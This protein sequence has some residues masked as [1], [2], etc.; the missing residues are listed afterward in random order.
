MARFLRRAIIPAVVVVVLF[1]VVF[2]IVRSAPEKSAPVA[3]DVGK[4]PVRVYG[5]IEPLGGPVFVGAQAARAVA[6]IAAA[7][8]DTV[9]AGQ[10]LVVCEN[11]VEVAQVAA[12]EGRLGAARRAWA[13]SRDSYQRAAG[14]YSAKGVSEQDFV[15]VR[16][17]AE[18]DSATMT[19]A[20]ADLELARAQLDRLTL[21]APVPGVVYK[22]DVRLGSTLAA[23]D[24]SKITLGAPQMQARLFV[25]SFWLGRVKVGDRYRLR[26]SETGQEVGAARVVSV[27]PYVGGRTVR[28]E[29]T[30]ERF[31][32]EY[33]VVIAELE[34]ATALPLG[35]NVVAEV[36][37]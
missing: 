24:D 26:D 36:A 5:T 25:E 32:A 10:A 12:A 37:E 22:L 27:S 29:D 14:L 19:A 13:I 23:G 28:S 3:P 6:R 20:A 30:G 1:F 15:Q 11:S 9:A 17:K 16:L 2:A 21:R 31:D 7:E 8:G 35:L 34:G 18:L 33:G 4:A